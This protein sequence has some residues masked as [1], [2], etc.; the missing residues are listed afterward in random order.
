MSDVENSNF[1]ITEKNK[2][3]KSDKEAYMIY[4]IKEIRIIR[5]PEEGEREK[6]A[7]KLFKDILAKNSQA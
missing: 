6:E 1:E 2:E 3:N 4:G 5:I 7:E